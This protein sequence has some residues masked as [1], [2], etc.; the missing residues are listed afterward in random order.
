MRLRRVV[1]YALVALVILYAGACLAFHWSQ[2]RLTF[3]EDERARPLPPFPKGFLW[4]TATSAHQ[5]EGGN[6]NDWSRFETQPGRI[7]RGERSGRAV[8]HWNRVAEDIGLMRALGANAYR[9]SI[10][11]AG[12]S[13]R[14]G[15][16][17]RR[18]G[19]TTRTSYGSSKPPAS[20][21]W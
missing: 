7:A 17:T 20:L 19:L 18:P 8:D 10:S 12:W 16:G 6:L 13:R 1:L 3:R 14:R 11:G 2:P 21:P 5:V 15:G 9:L 4:G